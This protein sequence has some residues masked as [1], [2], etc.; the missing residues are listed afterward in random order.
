M[1]AALLLR[2]RQS[3]RCR[4]K[5]SSSTLVPPAPAPAALTHSRTLQSPRRHKKVPIPTPL[6]A[7]A[8]ISAPR[9]ANTT[10]TRILNTTASARLYRTGAKTLFGARNR[11]YS[12]SSALQQLANMA[13]TGKW[14]APVVRKTFLDY[15]AERGHTIG[16][17]PSLTATTTTVTSHRWD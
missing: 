17:F 11:F 14:T 1:T 15:F 8:T 6:S 4:C 10:A 7:P 9:T 2:P 5:S 16:M 13:Y 3:C 12:S